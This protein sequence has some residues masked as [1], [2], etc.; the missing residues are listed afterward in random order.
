MFIIT[1]INSSL[2]TSFST[3]FIT[4]KLFCKISFHDLKMFWFCTS[5]TTQI[6]ICYKCASSSSL[7]Y[8]TCWFGE[9]IFTK[10]LCERFTCCSLAVVIGSEIVFFD[11]SIW[12][13]FTSQT[14]IERRSGFLEL[15]TCCCFFFSTPCL[16]VFIA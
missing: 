5:S 14:T 2:T 12:C 8:I 13:F 9:C 4:T 15:T 6:V 7:S 16:S 3:V 10:L 1:I 11:S